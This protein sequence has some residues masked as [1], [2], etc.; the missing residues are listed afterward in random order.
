[1]NTV[2]SKVK[3][4]LAASIIA[5]YGMNLLGP[6][7]KLPAERPLYMMES[8]SD[9]APSQPLGVLLAAL[10]KVVPK[11]SLVECGSPFYFFVSGYRLNMMIFF[12][13]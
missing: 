3:M 2:V 6:A 13:Y 9:I 1:M 12:H 4:V 5:F 7:A 10:A 11:G 8:A